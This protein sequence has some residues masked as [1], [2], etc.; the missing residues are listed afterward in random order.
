MKLTLQIK[1]LP[2]DEQYKGL[3][4]TLK[5]C[6]RVCNDISNIVWQSKTFNTF[7]LHHLVYRSIKKSS[8]LSA[9]SL[10]RCIGKVADS[11][12]PNKKVQ[13][14]FKSLGAVAYD[15]RILSYNI[16]K[17][18]ASIWSVDGRL[19]I[20][21]VCHNP[22]YLP[23]I[24]GEADFVYKKG[25][26]YLFQT[27]EVPEDDVKDIED[28]IGVDF[29]ITDIATLSDGTNFNSEKLNQIRDK[30]F[31]V[32]RS[33]QSKDTRGSR[34]LLKRLKGRERR[35]ATISNHTIAKRI[36]EKAISESK[37]IAIEDLTHIRE[38]TTVRKAQRRRHHSW[39]FFQLCSFLEY[40]AKLAGVPL[41]AVNPQYTSKTC[42][43]CKTI[44]NRNGKRFSC[45]SC[46][47]VTDADTNAAKN[48]AQLGAFCKQPRKDV[49]M[50][51][52]VSHVPLKADCFSCQ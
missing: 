29:G 17:Q 48:I 31:K 21:F 1:L 19:K 15:P 46:G 27:V 24:K 42:N 11:Y 20:P 44:G 47:N 37:G 23:Y 12:K 8:K 32:R 38:R 26:F 9:Q 10:V 33:V 5:E 39:S 14:R 50:L 43:V 2:D 45:P 36:V 6:N 25:K 34:K 52:L 49:S 22:K 4:E 13:R 35:F 16:E 40:K 51:N 3:I 30:R 28:F 41:V 18:I 7:K